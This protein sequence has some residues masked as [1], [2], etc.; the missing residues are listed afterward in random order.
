MVM[1]TR[2][3]VIGTAGHIDHGKTALIRA[4][5]GVDCDRLIE[6]KRRGITIDLGF[7]SFNGA[8][9]DHTP[10]RIS[11]VDVPGHKLFI[12]NM[13]AGAGCV[14]AVL[15]VVSA[16]EG[17][18]PQTEEH[19]AICM[20]LGIRRGI[21]AITKADLVG[22]ER[23]EEVSAKV[24]SFLAD[25]FLGQSDAA[26]I[27]VSAHTG[28]GLDDTRRELTSLAAS[29]SIEYPDTPLRLPLDRA[30]VM[31]GFVAVVTGTLLSGVLKTGQ[32]LV[33][34]PGK[35]AVR[36][37][38]MQIHNRT[39]D[40]A[41]PGSRVALNLSGIDASEIARGQTLVEQHA[42][43]AVALI[44]VE[45]ILL[46]GSASLKHR[47]NVHFHAFTSD[48][49]A[50]VSLY[51]YA[52]VEPGERRLLRL[53]LAQPVVIV[54]GDRFVLRQAS[55][56][57]TIGGGRVLD[58]YPLHSLRKASR[59]AWLEKVQYAPLEQQLLLRVERRGHAGIEYRDLSLEMGLQ[60]ETLQ[61]FAGPLI[62]RGALMD[63][64]TELLITA[65]QIQSVTCSVLTYVKADTLHAGL[66]RSEVISHL[67]LRPQVVDL[68]L[69]RLAAN[70]K[71]TVL[72]ERFYGMRADTSTA[73]SN[74][75]SAIAETFRLAK[76]ATPL[77]AEVA[78]RLHLSD[79]DMRRHMTLLLRDGVLVKMGNNEVYIHRD[80]LHA[81]RLQL[82]AWCGKTIDVG[83]F[84]DLTGLTRKHAIPLLEYLDRER[85]TRKL[86]DRRLVL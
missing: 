72:G 36:V 73:Q 74:A 85:I 46:P 45:V 77:A 49:L 69:A 18:K 8:A 5:T 60:Q 79:A 19:L 39:E 27:S 53:K 54:P 59:L 22:P 24:R 66:K 12:R 15:L 7:A 63:V 76:L 82:A 32:S 58:V 81:L 62:Q 71:L 16:E 9:E 20:L 67:R 11:F 14:A 29:T 23:L 61:R 25:S 43:S 35:R 75:Q 86:G 50:T 47:A 68:V 26:I 4:L 21:V 1:D 33:L 6:E 42:L 84:K 55:P 13:L 3:V 10:L 56:A 37:R 38:G 57:A 78:A 28:L 31:K 70:G 40:Q 2:S 41:Y 48:T 52:P 30:F 34:E 83:G 44:D 17:I 51:K 65:E 80:A 64:S